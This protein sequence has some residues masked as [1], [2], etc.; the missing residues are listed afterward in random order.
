MGDIKNR[1]GKNVSDFTDQ[2]ALNA[3]NILRNSSSNVVNKVFDQRMM[4]M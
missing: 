3:L 2:C 4:E 1:M